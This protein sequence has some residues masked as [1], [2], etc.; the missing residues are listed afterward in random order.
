MNVNFGLFPEVESSKV[1]ANGKI[2]KGKDR[3]REK[4]RAL[5]RRALNDLDAWRGAPRAAE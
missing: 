3:G 2:V 5:T 4:K 1:D